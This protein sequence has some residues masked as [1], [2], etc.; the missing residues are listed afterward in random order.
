MPEL[1][2]FLREVAS[3]T[4]KKDS[5]SPRNEDEAKRGLNRRGRFGLKGGQNES[6][7]TL[8]VYY[9]LDVVVRHGVC[10]VV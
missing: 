8:Q 4:D 1:K 3:E 9:I 5:S 7:F 2:L 10:R 6:S